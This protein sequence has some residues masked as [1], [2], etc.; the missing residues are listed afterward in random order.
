[1]WRRFEK[2]GGGAELRLGSEAGWWLKFRSPATRQ[3]LGCSDG[4][5]PGRDG[6]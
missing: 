4:L 1:M 2:V 5:I 6:S 3:D